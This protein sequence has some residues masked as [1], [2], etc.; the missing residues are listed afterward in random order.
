MKFYNECCLQ[1]TLKFLV[2]QKKKVPYNSETKI[3]NK[4]NQNLKN[5]EYE[6]YNTKKL[7]FPNEILQWMLFVDYFHISFWLEI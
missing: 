6:N 4:K 5:K 3:E 7:G 2:F 1:F